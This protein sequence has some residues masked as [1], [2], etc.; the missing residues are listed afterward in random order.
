MNIHRTEP[1]CSKSFLGDMMKTRLKTA[2]FFLLILFALIFTGCVDRFY[3]EGTEYHTGDL[4]TP[5][6]IDSIFAAISASV[7]EKY[8]VETDID[9]DIIVY[10]LTGGS[11][12]HQS[13]ECGSLTKAD[14]DNVNIGK[15]SDAYAD[16]KDRACKICSLDNDGGD[17][18][19]FTVTI[20]ETVLA[21]TT[22]KYPKEYDIDGELIVYWLESSD[23]WHESIRC[24]SL[25]NVT[26]DR[27]I[28]GGVNDALNA[29][30]ERV[31]KKCS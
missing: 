20:E 21:E 1:V 10:W 9:G 27:L 7:T 30:K 28:T 2:V 14:P 4:L 29:G 12:W 3:G 23:I 13:S 11:V 6:A 26:H 24:P 15:I 31:C 8:P 18:E 16:G 22:D 17:S 25:A 5:E 19:Y